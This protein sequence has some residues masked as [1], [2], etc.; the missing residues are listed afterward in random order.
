MRLVS[1]FESHGLSFPLYGCSVIPTNGAIIEV[2]GFGR[3]VANAHVITC[4]VTGASMHALHVVR[5]GHVTLLVYVVDIVR[6]GDGCG[7]GVERVGG[8]IRGHEMGRHVGGVRRGVQFG[9]VV[10]GGCECACVLNVVMFMYVV[11]VRAVVLVL[12]YFLVVYDLPFML[13]LL[14]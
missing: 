10:V 2:V 7:G 3:V 8:D 13:Y 11:P 1:V 12:G 4:V 14:V 5:C 6:V 9:S